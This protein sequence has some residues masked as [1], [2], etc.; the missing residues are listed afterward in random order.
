[1]SE[2]D[3]CVPYLET[4]AAYSLLARPLSYRQMGEG[5]GQTTD[6]RTG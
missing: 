6:C 4:S 5:I 1:M 2:F 3:F